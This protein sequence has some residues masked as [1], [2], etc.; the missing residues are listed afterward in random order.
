MRHDHTTTT[1]KNINV[2]SEGAR[3]D[4]VR[5]ISQEDDEEFTSPIDEVDELLYFAESFQ[6]VQQAVSADQLTSVMP[7]QS[8]H[9]L[10]TILQLVPTRAEEHARKQA[11]EAAMVANGSKAT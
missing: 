10:Q 11:I 7:D 8:K 4:C 2:H 3:A 5:R 9:Q 6:A 1:N